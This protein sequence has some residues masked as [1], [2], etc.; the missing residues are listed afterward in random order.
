LDI[1]GGLCLKSGKRVFFEENPPI[2]TYNAI[3][4]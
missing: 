1:D 4:S 2:F 3:S